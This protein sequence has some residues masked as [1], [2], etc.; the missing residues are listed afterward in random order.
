MAK[1]SVA[2]ASLQSCMGCHVSLLDLD[3]ELLDLFEL[4]EIKC[5]PL[6]D[7]KHPPAVEVALI[8]G[9]VANCQ[10]EK[11][12]EEFRKQAQLLVAFGTCAC[13]GGIPGMRNLYH[14]GDVLGRGYIETESTIDGR[15]PD[16]AELPPLL[17][18]VKPLKDVVNVDYAIPGCPPV[19]STIKTVLSAL[20]EGQEP[21]LPSRNLCEE[22][23]REHR[24]MLMPQRGFLTEEVKAICEVDRIDPEKCF[25][26]QGI[27]CMG[28]ATREGCGVRCLRGNM[29]CRGCMGPTPNAMEQGAKMINAIASILP[30]GGLMFMEDVVGTGYRFSVPVSI[31]PEI[32]SKRGGVG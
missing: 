14:R 29:P 27:I 25:L 30:A 1:L 26:E 8:E 9:A 31:Y 5:T 20:A 3:E 21:V 22:C 4:A 6:A 24:D 15:R 16:G 11:V 10:N 19:P 2:T 28:P 32:A 7:V 18:N 12:L 13:F 17:K 23:P